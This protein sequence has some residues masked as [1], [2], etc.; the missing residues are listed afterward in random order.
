MRLT[1]EAAHKERRNAAAPAANLTGRRPLEGPMSYLAEGALGL[2]FGLLI[3]LFLPILGLLLIIFGTIMLAVGASREQ[4][5]Q[6]RD[7]CGW[8][9]HDWRN[10]LSAMYPGTRCRN[11]L[12]VKGGPDVNMGYVPVVP[13]AYGPYGYPPAAAPVM[14][15][16]AAPTATQRAAYAPPVQQFVC[17]ACRSPVQAG[18]QFC[19]WCNRPFGQ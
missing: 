14:V 13:V 11:C 18:M 17:P 8:L 6:H 10:N 15:M 19:P 4:P 12:K 1:F 7:R 5:G 2:V 9:G 3:V 16:P